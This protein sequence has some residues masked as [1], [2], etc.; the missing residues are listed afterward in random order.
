MDV[1]IPSLKTGVISFNNL[2]SKLLVTNVSYILKGDAR[3]AEIRRDIEAAQKS[4]DQSERA[5]SAELRKIDTYYEE[6]TVRKGDLTNK[7][8]EKKKQREN[9]IIELNQCRQTLDACYQSLAR[10]KG[11]ASEANS[12]LQNARHK[13]EESMNLRDAGFGLLAIP[14]IGWIAG[15]KSSL[16]SSLCF[17]NQCL[18][19]V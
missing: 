19:N 11:K 3:F 2:A 12:N 16:E 15:E 10:A 9:L 13:Q 18:Y 1:V 4:I 14:V 17:T 7:K 8:T 6:L 5:A